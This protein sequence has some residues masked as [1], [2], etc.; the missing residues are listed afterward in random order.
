MY[1]PSYISVDTI[2]ARNGLIFQYDAR[3]FSVSYL[4]RQLQVGNQKFVYQKIKDTILFDK[5]GIEFKEGYFMA[6]LER[7]FLD[8]LYLNSNFYFDNLQ[9]LDQQ[10]LQKIVSIY[11]SKKLLKTLQS[12]NFK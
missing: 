4:S 9:K 8:K 10:K 1:T 3:V 2:L 7:A 5:T 12:F 6:T 11:N